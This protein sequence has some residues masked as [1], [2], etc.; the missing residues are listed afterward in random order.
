LLL[1]SLI[2]W[3]KQL[4]IFSWNKQKITK[5]L[6]VFVFEFVYEASMLQLQTA[7]GPWQNFHE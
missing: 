1:V 5:D 7:S 4:S 3:R 2:S 6:W